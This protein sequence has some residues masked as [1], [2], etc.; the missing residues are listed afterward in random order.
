M[1]L[2]MEPTENSEKSEPQMGFEPTTLCNLF[3]YKDYL[4]ITEV[5]SAISFHIYH[6]HICSLR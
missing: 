6:S 1:K 5:P 4:K 3:D 2:L